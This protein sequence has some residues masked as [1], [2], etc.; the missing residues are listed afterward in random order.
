MISAEAT[1]ESEPSLSALLFNTL[2]LC[3]EVTEESLAKVVGDCVELLR[4]LPEFLI[5]FELVV[6]L[7]VV[8]F[9][10]SYFLI[11]SYTLV[12]FAKRLP[13]PWMLHRLIWSPS[14]QNSSKLWPQM[15]WTEGRANS[16]PH[17]SQFFWSKFFACVFISLISSRMASIL[18]VIC[19]TPFFSTSPF[20]FNSPSYFDLMT[21]Y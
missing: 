1:L 19:F 11:K 4:F 9:L 5:E 18:S 13:W 12:T 16:F 15:K 21:R 8:M 10:T 2:Q 14:T 6:S 17:W 20:L 7:Q 3:T